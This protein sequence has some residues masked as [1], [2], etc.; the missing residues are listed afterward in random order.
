MATINTAHSKHW[1]QAQSIPHFYTD[2]PQSWENT[3]ILT[4]DTMELYNK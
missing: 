2:D 3:K 1:E 4:S